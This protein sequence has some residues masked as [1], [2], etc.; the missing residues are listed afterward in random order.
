VSCF[1]L[2]DQLVPDRVIVFVRQIRLV[3]AQHSKQ[4]AIADGGAIFGNKGKDKITQG[5]GHLEPSEGA[6][7]SAK[8]K[9]LQS[10]C[11]PKL[12]NAGE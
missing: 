1:T 10:N 11:S 6:A 7:V 3:F 4:G 9:S 2:G 12:L 5:I 8:L